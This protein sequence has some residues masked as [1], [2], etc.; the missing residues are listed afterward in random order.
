MGLAAK[1]PVKAPLALAL[2]AVTALVVL[3]P[4]RPPLTRFWGDEPTYVAMSASLAFDRDLVFDPGD[5][6]REA[7]AGRIGREVLILERTDRGIAYSKPVLY[8]LLAAPFYRLLGVSGL[9]VLNA[10]ALAIGLALGY[11]FLRRTAPAPA[12]ALTLVTFAGAGALLPYAGWRMVEA[13][14]VAMVLSGLSLA[15][16]QDRRTGDA[17][18]GRLQRILA[19][20]FAPVVG[21]VLLGLAA[22]LRI[23]NATLAAVPALGL[24]LAGRRARALAAG[25]TAALAFVLAGLLSVALTGAFNPYRALRAGFNAETGFPIG[26]DAAIAAARFDGIEENATNLTG[27][28]PRLQPA[29]TLYASLYFL[30]G[31]HTGIVF[32]FPL[33]V[34]LLAAALCRPDR[35]GLALLAGAGLNVVYYLVWQP[36]NY[37]GGETF[38]GNRYFLAAYPALLLAP[39]VVPAR[40]LLFLAWAAALVAWVSAATSLRL[41]AGIDRSSQSHA[42]AGVFRLLPYESTALELEVRADRYWSGDFVRF[43]DPFATAGGWSFSLATGKPP[44]EMLVADRGTSES[45]RFLVAADA[46]EV[47]IEHA[48]WLRRR[49]ARLGPDPAGARAIVELKL[50]PAW[51]RHEFW[52]ARE[53]LYRVRTLRLALRTP[54]GRP[55]RATL[56]YLGDGAAL[57]AVFAREVLAAELPAEVAAGATTTLTVAVRNTSRAVWTSDAVLPVQIGYRVT[58]LAPGGANPI[59]GP[60]TR[61]SHEVKPGEVLRAVVPVRWPAE[62]GDYRFEVDLVCEELA[63]FAD[64]VGAPVATATVRVAPARTP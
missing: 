18:A 53:P 43:V 62:P 31:R 6:A 41:T 60:R 52:W 7:S 3:L 27:I 33:A 35:T 15:L 28:V 51:R 19:W 12:A 32:Y 2:A 57:D 37:F 36:G 50:S 34:V 14:E 24:W 63:W 30:V 1:S 48:D 61:L 59:E 42:A 40:R 11:A 45:V 55:A 10:A 5:L 46:P 38:I 54:D 25:T 47:E 20:R 4:G 23:P 13:V 21:W 22:A 44:A 58:A 17:P 64:R 56:F 8:P 16:G 26:P 39:T 49:T 9:L 29:R